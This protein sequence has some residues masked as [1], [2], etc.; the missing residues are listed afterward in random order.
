MA[1]VAAAASSGKSVTTPVGTRTLTATITAV[2]G[3]TTPTTV[4]YSDSASSSTA[5]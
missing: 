3:T 5:A 4:I 1:P 2:P